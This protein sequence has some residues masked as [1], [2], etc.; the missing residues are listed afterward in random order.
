[1]PLKQCASGR[2]DPI[3]EGQRAGYCRVGPT[4]GFRSFPQPPPRF[5]TTCSVLRPP[6]R[7]WMLENGL[8]SAG[9]VRR[10]ASRRRHVSQCRTVPPR[11][12]RST[13][14]H[15]RH[16]TPRAHHHGVATRETRANAPIATPLSP[17]GLRWCG[18]ASKSTYVFPMRPARFRA[19]AP[20]FAV[21]MPIAMRR[22][23]TGT[24]EWA[25][26]GAAR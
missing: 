15:G 26:T 14:Q 6:S 16:Q 4:H 9:V 12:G 24:Q 2:A 21:P 18:T 23:G 8:A 17:L 20:L 19:A 13:R 5:P 7:A 22:V 25:K 1:M 3:R 10:G 11:E